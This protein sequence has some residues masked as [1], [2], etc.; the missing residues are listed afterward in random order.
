MVARS[1]RI[2]YLPNSN[3]RFMVFACK[4]PKCSRSLFF[5]FCLLACLQRWGGII[6]TKSDHIVGTWMARWLQTSLVT[7]APLGEQMAL[8]VYVSIELCF[9]CSFECTNVGKI[10]QAV[11]NWLPSYAVPHQCE[12]IVPHIGLAKRDE[13]SFSL[14]LYYL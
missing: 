12:H 3:A 13:A 6:V 1:V 7:M 2:Q 11:I 8:S 4:T 5:F 9:T 10:A 14:S